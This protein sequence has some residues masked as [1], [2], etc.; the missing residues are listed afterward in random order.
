MFSLADNVVADTLDFEVWDC[1]TSA[2]NFL[3]LIASV[4]E[5]NDGCLHWY[6]GQDLLTFNCG[7]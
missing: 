7:Y 5:K 6:F 3:S 2:M 4:Y 1:K